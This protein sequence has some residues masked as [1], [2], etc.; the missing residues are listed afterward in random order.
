M[1]IR[2]KKNARLFPIFWGGET[3]SCSAVLCVL[4]LFELIE[5]H[6]YL[7]LNS[8]KKINNKRKRKDIIIKFLLLR[9]R[10][11]TKQH[12][13]LCHPLTL[14]PATFFYIVVAAPCKYDDGL[15]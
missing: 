11:R 2:Y 8:K 1:E 15:I 3:C 12:G 6:K 4:G 9:W 10:N 5:V 7:I 14:S 13:T